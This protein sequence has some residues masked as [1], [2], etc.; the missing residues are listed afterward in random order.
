MKYAMTKKKVPWIMIILTKAC[1]CLENYLTNKE[2]NTT[3]K[4]AFNKEE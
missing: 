1:N 3:T 4:C 2:W